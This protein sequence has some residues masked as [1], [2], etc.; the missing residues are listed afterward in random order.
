[1]DKRFDKSVKDKPLSSLEETAL[2]Q[3]IS[4]YKYTRRKVDECLT[5]VD[6]IVTQIKTIVDGSKQ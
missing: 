3:L 5:D 6:H 4:D 1:M 2:N